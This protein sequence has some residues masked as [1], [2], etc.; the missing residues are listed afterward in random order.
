MVAVLEERTPEVEA[1]TEHLE[2]EV[3]TLAA[4]IAAATSRFVLLVAELD[5]REAWKEWGCQSMAHWLAWKA[6]MG[7][8]AAR[9]HVR[10][11]RALE[12]L[13]V[14]A[15]E[16]GA[17]RL[18]FS[19]VRAVTRVA[20]PTTESALVD[21]AK[22]A[23]A[24]QLELAIRGYERTRVDP[25]QARDQVAKRHFRVVHEDDGTATLIVRMTRDG[26]E[27]VLASVDAAETEI[28]RDVDR[29]DSAESRRV[30][31]LELVALHFLAGRSERVPTEIVVHVENED[32]D[33]DTM[34]PVLARMTCDTA[35]RVQTPD[36]SGRRKQTIPR[37]LRRLIARRDKQCCRFPGCGNRRFLHVHHIVH[38]ARGGP[39]DARNCI[40]L[41]TFHHRAVHEG[42]WRVHGNAQNLLG[43][44]FVSPDGKRL[45]ENARDTVAVP[46][47][48][49]P[50]GIDASTIATTLREPMDLDHAVTAL[51]SLFRTERAD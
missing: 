21:F 49:S 32:L 18:S 33:A 7:I 19:K 10:V 9:Q 12:K 48:E 2:A 24:A 3:C 6:G 23:T 13:P 1:T 8:V 35:V 34:S 37:A 50:D 27:N 26:I 16:F 39:T 4:Q 15:E 28:P 45:R 51:H 38:E 5:R 43:L 29:D 14:L 17:G 40:L 46:P 36:S 31:A 25:E 44:V 20:T 22:V 11:G 47:L 30:D 41:C 42:A